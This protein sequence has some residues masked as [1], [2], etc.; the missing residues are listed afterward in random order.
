MRCAIATMVLALTVG[1]G[2][3]DEKAPAKVPLPYETT[4]KWDLDT[5]EKSPAFKLVKREVKENQVIWILENRRNLG[6]EITF[7]YQAAFY[8]EDG[9]QLFKVE[10]ETHPWFLNMPQ[11]ERNRFVLNLPKSEKWK[12]VRKVVIKNGEYN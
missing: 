10:F 11:G 5:F 3:S 1:R 4:V 12:L 6:T 8:D 7:G 2:W 9:I